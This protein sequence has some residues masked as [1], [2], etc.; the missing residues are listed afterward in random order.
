MKLRQF[1]HS[2]N[3]VQR[4]TDIMAHSGQKITFCLAGFLRFS[5]CILQKLLC[6]PLLLQRFLLRPALSVNISG[7]RDLDQIIGVGAVHTH[8]LC[9]IPVIF[10]VFPLM[11]HL[12]GDYPL[13]SGKRMDQGK[14]GKLLTK[15]LPVIRVDSGKLGFNQVIKIPLH[16]GADN[17]IALIF[18]HV[19]SL[20]RQVNGYEHLICKPCRCGK[21]CDFQIALLFLQKF[22]L[23]I[24]EYQNTPA[25]LFPQFI[26]P[27][28]RKF[29]HMISAVRGKTAHT[30]G[31]LLFP[32]T[33]QT[34]HG[35]PGKVLIEKLQV[36]RVQYLLG[37]LLIFRFEI[38]LLRY[39]RPHGIFLTIHIIIPGQIRYD[40]FIENG[41][42]ALGVHL[43]NILDPLLFL[44]ARAVRGGCDH[45]SRNTAIPVY[46]VRRHINCGLQQRIITHRM[47]GTAVS[48]SFHRTI[49]T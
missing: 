40:T 21:L 3:S 15:F 7:K 28:C 35:L 2:H 49:S 14:I 4:R 23:Y 29:H 33:E 46:P 26:H 5:Q 45:H 30:P 37:I 24:T 43:L 27:G 6:A 41:H 34:E 12:H 11:G 8:Y 1:C 25:L 31:D 9:K 36:I 47:A 17:R 48:H 22:V 18:Q 10:S 32:F 38:A 42:Q 39:I 20:L 16:P 44:K 19:I 13:S